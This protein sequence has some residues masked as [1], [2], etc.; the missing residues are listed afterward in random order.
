MSDDLWI[1][2]IQSAADVEALAPIVGWAFGA[3][4]EESPAWFD[5]AGRDNLRVAALGQTIVG[6]LV[7]L[8]M[9]QFFG[10]RSVPMVGIAG[11]AVAPEHR[12]R[13]AALSL[14]Q[15]SV[16]ELAARGVA[17]STLY[18]ATQT[19]YRA[20][21][22][23]QAGTRFRYLLVPRELPVLDRELELRQLTD[24]DRAAVER[25]YTLHAATADG[26]LDR[27]AYIWDRV[28]APRSGKAFGYG[29]FV[30]GE[31]EGYLYILQRHTTGARY[32]L[33]L[34][35]VVALSPR[36]G[37]RLLTFLADH[38]SLGE[39]LV[40]HGGPADSLL[41][42][43]PEQRYR[44]TLVDQWMLRITNVQAAL[45]ARGYPVGVQLSLELE[46]AD[47]DVAGNAGLWRLEVAD[48]RGQLRR[49]GRG[50]LRAGIR[51]L[52]ALYSGYLD[53]RALCR[54]GLIDGEDEDLERAR[55]V[56]SGP[57]P[58]MPDTF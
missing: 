23:E 4:A 37:R 45:E 53:P 49:G 8:P 30:N 44:M 12:G 2:P 39:N 5:K 46:L 6:G 22:Y 24:A 18:P 21:G 51:G 28:R 40:W 38:R 26:W 13:R 43:L 36:A 17:L 1:R 20:A 27:G 52:A 10:G 55:S 16:R 32:E 9:G 25:V 3:P 29:A 11:V 48:G 56:F 34:G 14:M 7:Q 33:T 57:S 35:D 15:S 31:L 50:T 47:P 42:L 41:A 58:G 19:L 54:A